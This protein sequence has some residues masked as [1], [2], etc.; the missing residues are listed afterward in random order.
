M[1]KPIPHPSWHLWSHEESEEEEDDD[2]HMSVPEKADVDDE[3]PV[4][5][6]QDE[7]EVKE[8]PV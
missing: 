6:V 3:E 7:P 2:D 4:E 1:P 8:E 5:P